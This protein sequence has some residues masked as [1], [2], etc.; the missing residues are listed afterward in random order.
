MP[1]LQV[2]SLADIRRAVAAHDPDLF[3]IAASLRAWSTAVASGEIPATYD[4][5][6]WKARSREWEFYFR[7]LPD[8]VVRERRREPL[9]LIPGDQV[10][11]SSDG[12]K[13]RP[14]E[15]PQDREW[16]F[17]Y[18]I[19]S[20]AGIVVLPRGTRFA[21]TRCKPSDHARPEYLLPTG[22]PVEATGTNPPYTRVNG[23]DLK[24]FLSD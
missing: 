8:H 15:D 10:W 5:V 11:I 14:L 12:R 22:E 9:W 6:E 24:C 19:V 23:N 18:S 13:Y 20:G 21:P 2:R 1:R 4:L 17:R 16:P 7:W 3:S